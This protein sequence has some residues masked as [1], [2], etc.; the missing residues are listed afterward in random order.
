MNKPHKHAELI[1]AWA[2]GAVIQY[3]IGRGWSDYAKGTVAVPSW[4]EPHIKFRIKPETVRYR[5]GL[6]HSWNMH[7]GV[8]ICVT[9][10]DEETGVAAMGSFIKWLGDWAEVEV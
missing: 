10:E 6:K 7:T 3:D 1:K 5:L 2:D 8:V 4:N 9:N